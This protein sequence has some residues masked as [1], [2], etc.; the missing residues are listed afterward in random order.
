MIARTPG[1]RDLREGAQGAFLLLLMNDCPQKGVVFLRTVVAPLKIKKVD[2]K[3]TPQGKRNTESY[4]RKDRS[5]GGR[6]GG[7]GGVER[8]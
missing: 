7:V 6:K 3:K 2:R 4:Q 5:D 1:L 8:M